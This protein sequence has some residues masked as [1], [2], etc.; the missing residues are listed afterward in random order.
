MMSVSMLWPLT[1]LSS[2]QG[3]EITVSLKN[4]KDL[5]QRLHGS[6]A[7]GLLISPGG[8]D[9]LVSFIPMHMVA[10]VCEGDARPELPETKSYGVETVQL[11]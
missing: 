5:F 9:A 1:W 11:P 2:L 6:D 10:E 4:G 3:K 8:E 7:S